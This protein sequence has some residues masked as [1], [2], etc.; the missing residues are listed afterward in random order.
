VR[1]ACRGGRVELAGRAVTVSTVT[2]V[3]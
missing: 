2:M 1:M 3:V